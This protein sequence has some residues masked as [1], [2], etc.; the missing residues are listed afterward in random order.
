MQRVPPEFFILGTEQTNPEAETQSSDNLMPSFL[1][2][3]TQA[4]PHGGNRV[5]DKVSSLG[6]HEKPRN[7]TLNITIVFSEAPVESV[8]E[9]NLQMADHDEG[10]GGHARVPLVQRERSGVIA[11]SACQVWRHPWR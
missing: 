7:A 10:G 3:R 4:F 6:G 5:A 1:A 11:I 8:A 2:Q 9:K